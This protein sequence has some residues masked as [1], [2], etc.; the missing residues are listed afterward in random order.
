KMTEFESEHASAQSEIDNLPE[1]LSAFEQELAAQAQAIL[2]YLETNYNYASIRNRGW[3]ERSEYEGIEYRLQQP[4][5][6]CDG[7]Y[8]N[9]NSEITREAHLLYNLLPTKKEIQNVL[10][11]ADYIYAYIENEISVTAAPGEYES[12]SFAIKAFSNLSAME[13]TVSNLEKAGAEAIPASNIDIY[14]VKCW[15]QNGV[16]AITYTEGQKILVPE[17]LLKD[18]SLIN[19]DTVNQENYIK[20]NGAYVW[21]S[22]PTKSENLYCPTNAEFPV[23][24]SSVLLPVNIS[25]AELKQFWLTV[26][27][28]DAAVEGEYIGHISFTT[29]GDGEIGR[30]KIAVNVL[31]FTLED[32]PLKYSIYYRGQLTANGEGTIS[33]EFKSTEQYTNEIIDMFKHG[34]DNAA[35]YQAYTNDLALLQ[36]ALGLRTTAGMDK[37]VLYYLG[38]STGSSTDPAVLAVLKAK[39]TNIRNTAAPYGITDVYI[40]GQ[41]EAAGDD[42]LKQREAWEAV[43]EAEGKVFVA[44]FTDSLNSEYPY[45]KS[46]YWHFDEGTETAVSDSSGWGN[47]G[48]IYGASWGTGKISYGLDFN[49]DDYVDCGSNA[50]LDITNA[51]TIEAWIKP[52]GSGK[53]RRIIEKM[54]TS[55]RHDGYSIRLT[56]E[57]KLQ[58]I[59]TAG[60]DVTTTGTFEDGVWYHIVAVQAGTTCKKIYVNGVEDGNKDNP[61]S[62]TS[63]GTAPLRIGTKSYSVGEYF[64]GTIDEVRIYNR[65]LGIEEIE[66]NYQDGINGTRT[67]VGDLKDLH[68]CAGS[69]S[70]AEADKSHE[71]TGHEIFSYMNP[72]AGLENPEI[73]RRNFGLCLWKYGYDG[74]MD[75]AYHST[76][77]GRGF[78]WNDFDNA[79]YRDHN[80]TYPTINGV[81]DTIA[82]EGFREGVDDARYM[83]TLEKAI[84]EAPASPEK[85]EAVA[86]VNSL[87]ETY[88][89]E[90]GYLPEIRSKIINYIIILTA[91]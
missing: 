10:P 86:Y 77:G 57:D 12:A 20:V 7:I 41:D 43:H 32:T 1:D 56:L 3:L 67:T 78:T 80:F 58:F 75:F 9:R 76:G 15:Y 2:S 21:I 85:D 39:V 36:N 50:S 29:P 46:G 53:W 34:I 17:L 74:A 40:Y 48:V 33:P 62:L 28:P 64:E 19:V 25:A 79:S 68:I 31:P 30:Y 38:L 84:N 82:W 11:D 47:D 52:D 63:S 81:I 89:L 16:N 23:Q 71:V 6:I 66:K 22:D 73:Y 87:K 26:K 37:T 60:N 14:A 72:Q 45:G 4:A 61:S 49:G 5:G 83:A 70:V 8:M 59:T 51:L 42:L 24:D 69:L 27:V 55:F 13:V 35:I 65:A 88:E 18:D 90:F 44:G 54:S 91:L